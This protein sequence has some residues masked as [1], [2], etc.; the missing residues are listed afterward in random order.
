MS[1]GPDGVRVESDAGEQLVPNSVASLM[2][3]VAA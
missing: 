2:Y 3:V 1:S